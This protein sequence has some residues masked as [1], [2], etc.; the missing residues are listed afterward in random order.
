MVGWCEVKIFTV[1]TGVTVVMC[2]LAWLGV[3]QRF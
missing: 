2:L 1:F 3:F